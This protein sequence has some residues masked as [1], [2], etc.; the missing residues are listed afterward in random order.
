MSRQQNAERNYHL[1][2][3]NK[4]LKLWQRSNIWEQ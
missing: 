3:A 2:I 1:M 4:S